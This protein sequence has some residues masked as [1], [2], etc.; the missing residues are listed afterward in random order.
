[1][2]DVTHDSSLCAFLPSN[3]TH[4]YRIYILALADST[5]P[6]MLLERLLMCMPERMCDCDWALSVGLHALQQTSFHTTSSQGIYSQKYSL[7]TAK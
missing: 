2:P 7:A 6:G 1:M 4:V 5:H 3:I